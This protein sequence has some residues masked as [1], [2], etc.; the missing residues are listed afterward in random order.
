MRIPGAGRL[1]RIARTVTSVVRR[2]SPRGLV[3]LYH[4]VAGPRFDPLRLDVSAANF[5]AQLSVLRTEATVLA[6]DEFEAHRRR[7]TLPDRAAAITFDD[8]YADNLQVAAPALAR[9]ALP[10]TVFVTTGMTGSMREFWWDDLERVVTTGI[11]LDAPVPVAGV[12]W[13]R[14]LAAAPLHA[15]WT[16][17]IHGHQSPRAQLYLDLFGRLRPM[18]AQERDAAMAALRAWASVPDAPRESHRTMS[19]TELRELAGRPGIGIGAHTVSHPVLALLSAADQAHELLE[20]RRRAEALTG[21]AVLSAAYP[22]G[23]VHDVSEETERAARAAG[24]GFALANEPGAAWRW[25]SPWR[26]PRHLVRDWTADE[27]RAKLH[28]WWAQ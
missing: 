19:E 15:P 16:I 8:G 11:A 24:L 5:D 18:P 13:E 25:S 20:S 3:L 27:F 23:T 12:P 1:W 9:Q 2:R 4:R 21:R 6:L 14:E 7:G 26:I 28:A 17:E 10:A 22:Y